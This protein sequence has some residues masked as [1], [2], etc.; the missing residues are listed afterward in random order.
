M[1]FCFVQ[2][3]LFGQQNINLGTKN[4]YMLRLDL[5]N[6]FDLSRSVILDRSTKQLLYLL[7]VILNF[8]N[9]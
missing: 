1:V 8:N 4:Q 6:S 7:S 2:N 9:S 3:L 5:E